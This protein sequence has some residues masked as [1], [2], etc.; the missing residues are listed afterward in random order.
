MLIGEHRH[1]LDSK[2]NNHPNQARTE[3]EIPILTKGLMDDL[4]IS[5][6]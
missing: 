6:E 3:L 1:S 5:H 2:S 4:C